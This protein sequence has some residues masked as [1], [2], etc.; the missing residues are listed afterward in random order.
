[1][2]LVLRQRFPD[3]VAHYRRAAEGWPE[4]T[5]IRVNLA[6]T[7][8]RIGDVNGAIRELDTA[9]R[10]HRSDPTPHIIAGRLLVEHA[11]PAEAAERFQLAL[12]IAPGDPDARQGLERARALLDNQ[13]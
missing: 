5:E 2:L 9:S 10:G 6:L 13:R 1:M 3:A 4:N 12:E 7:L 8:A 11:R